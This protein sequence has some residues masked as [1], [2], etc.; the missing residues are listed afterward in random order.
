MVFCAM[1]NSLNK[2][3][4][5]EEE[6]ESN[7]IKW[8]SVEAQGSTSISFYFGYSHFIIPPGGEA[9]A[10]K[11]K[12]W[13]S[14]HGQ[15]PPV[16]KN[17]VFSLL[18]SNGATTATTLEFDVLNNM[19]IHFLAD[20]EHRYN[21]G[22]W[23]NIPQNQDWDHALMTLAFFF[24]STYMGPIDSKLPS[25]KNGIHIKNITY[26]NY[27]LRLYFSDSA[28]NWINPISIVEYDTND[29]DQGIIHNKFCSQGPGD[30]SGT[31]GAWPIDIADPLGTDPLGGAPGYRATHIN[32][33][34]DITSVCTQKIPTLKNGESYI[35][36]NYILIQNLTKS[37]IFITTPNYTDFSN[38]LIV[39]HPASYFKLSAVQI[40]TYSN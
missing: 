18:D 3:E 22:A 8:N 20:P 31:P 19:E 37:N 36:P 12:N 21:G 15:F 13:K 28:G 5:E 34:S 6:E 9:G 26:S 4:E 25:E 32:D 29:I 38:I 1:L 10:I 39:G 2:V 35:H 16:S 17:A 14:I 27:E 24:W 11:A 40:T 23:T 30:W 7:Y 33:L